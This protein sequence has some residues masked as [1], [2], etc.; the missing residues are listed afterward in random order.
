M[1]GTLAP[2]VNGRREWL[3]NMLFTVDNRM[4]PFTS[5]ARK[6][7]SSKS[8]RSGIPNS[9]IGTYFAKV[10]GGFKPGGVADGK[11]VGAFDSQPVREGISFRP[12]KYRRAPMVG[13]LLEGDD[14]A[15]VNS[16]WMEAIADQTIMHKRDMEKEFLSDQ[17]SSANG[18]AEGGTTGRGLGRWINNTAQAGGLSYSEL[19]VPQGAQTPAAQIFIG[20]IGDGV[21]TGLTEDVISTLLQSRWDL[22]GDSSKLVGLLG[23]ALKNRFSFFSKYKANVAN[24]TVI[25]RTNTDD[26]TSGELN[27]AA[28]DVYQ[29]DWGTFSLLPVSTIFLPDQYRGYFIDSE[30]VEIRSRYWMREK[31]LPDLGGG[32]REL[33]ESFVA[34]IPGD[35]RSHVKIAG[36]A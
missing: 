18:G 24:A 2:N 15:G 19:P 14:I 8:E 28:V 27:G 34:L 6:P 22:T 20:S 3:M 1:P 12:E 5:M 25:V 35:L 13:E 11:D 7:S 17:D 36:A 16:E 29:S 4:M 9:Q 23:A 33:I 21:T 32:P 30:H 26:F 10:Y 31:S